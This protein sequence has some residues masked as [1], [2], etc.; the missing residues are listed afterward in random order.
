M[1]YKYDTKRERCLKQL[2]L[3]NKSQNTC[4]LKT[5]QHGFTFI[6]VKVYST[7]ENEKKTHNT[8]DLQLFGFTLR[9]QLSYA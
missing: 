1:K 4:V 3:F 2:R 5:Q 8:H 7:N 6:T 9:F